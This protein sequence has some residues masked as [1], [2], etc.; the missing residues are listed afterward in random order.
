MRSPKDADAAY[1]HGLATLLSGKLED[2]E[3]ILRE[4]LALAPRS[5]EVRVAMAKARRMAKDEAGAQKLLEEALALEP[6]APGA[7]CDLAVL[8]LSKPGGAARAREV[9]APALV[10]HPKDAG[11]NL[12]MALA[13]AD[14]DKG[15]AREYARKA[16]ASEDKRIREQADKLLA[17]LSA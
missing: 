15:R 13:L 7:V 1:L 12:N 5:V 10:A 8:H 3:R 16:Q 9:L 11:L 14:S 2:A 4:T 17:S 6:H